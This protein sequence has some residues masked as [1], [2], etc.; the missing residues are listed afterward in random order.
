[1]PQRL[2]FEEAQGEHLFLLHKL[3]D[4]WGDQRL[5]RALLDRAKRGGFQLA[6]FRQLLRELVQREV[7]GAA[8][9][10]ARS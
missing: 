9:Y 6:T 2:A 1:M 8:A 7:P 5:R 10:A 4:C 3:R